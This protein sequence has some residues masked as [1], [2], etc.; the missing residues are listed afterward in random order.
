M[1]PTVL[2]Y[3]L[4]AIIAILVFS[5]IH[6]FFIIPPKVSFEAAE[7]AGYL[8]MT[9]SMV[10]V[11][12]GIKHFR[13]H[14][15]NGTLSFGQGM[16]VGLLIALGPAIFFALFDLLYVKVINPGWSDEYYSHYVQEA[17][18]GVPAAELPGKL[19]QIEDQK[20]F[21]EQPAMLFL[22]MFATVFI[23]GCIVT[24]ISALTLRRKRQLA[25]A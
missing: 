3:S 18:R 13:D 17:T 1:K 20:A 6:V 15:N 21:F 10:F 12:F 9:L 8:T 2:R 14:V 5:A 25:N 23:I 11:F 7:V 4:F 19:K 16:K 22:V 24:I